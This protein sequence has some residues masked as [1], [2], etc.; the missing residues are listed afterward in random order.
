MG[1]SSFSVGRWG[2]TLLPLG[3]NLFFADKRSSRHNDVRNKALPLF[4]IHFGCVSPLRSP[5]VGSTRAQACNRTR[6]RLVRTYQF[7]GR[8]R[9]RGRASRIA[10]AL[11]VFCFGYCELHN[12]ATGS[13]RVV[14]TYA[15]CSPLGMLVGRGGAVSVLGRRARLLP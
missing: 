4:E 6:R 15:Q 12:N 13:W 8:V 14:C 11:V 2:H 3:P 9:A 5:S 1:E 10:H 7:L